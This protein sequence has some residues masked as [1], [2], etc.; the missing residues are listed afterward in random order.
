M[1]YSP[2]FGA[3]D[4]IESIT[5]VSCDKFFLHKSCAELPPHIQNSNN[6]KDFPK[7]RFQHFFDDLC[8]YFTLSLPPFRCSICSIPLLWNVKQFFYYSFD[9]H[10][11]VCI[12]CAMFQVESSQDTELIRHAAHSQHLLALIQRPSSFKCNACTLEYNVRDASYKCTECPFWMHKTCADAP[13]SLL[14]EFHNKHPLTLSYFLPQVYHKFIQYCSLCNK[15]FSRL[16]W[17]YCCPGC[18]LLVHFRC[19]RSSRIFSCSEIEIYDSDLVHLPAADESSVDR[20]G[21]QFIKA[22]T[23]VN[24][25]KTIISKTECVRH[26]AHKEHHLQLTTI[27]DDNE[28]VLLCDCCVKPIRTDNDE[29]YACVPCNYFLH[30]VCAEFPCMIEHHLMGGTTLSVENFSALVFDLYECDACKC[31]FNCIFFTCH[32]ETSVLL[33]FGCGIIPKS[34]KHEAHRHQ[35]T[36]VFSMKNAC[37]ACGEVFLVKFKHGCVECDYYLCGRCIMKAR[38]AKHPWDPHPLH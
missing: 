1:S 26:Q 8:D 3:Y 17:L 10:V 35:L 25:T 4:I 12:K 21:E 38:T 23:S 2:A 34:L 36:L 16:D 30:K 37:K 11:R 28:I 27:S 32:H 9:T 33:H 13:A 19:A 22:V 18:R 20:L 24:S 31:L 5:F 29:F 7:L 15:T 14:L 6:P